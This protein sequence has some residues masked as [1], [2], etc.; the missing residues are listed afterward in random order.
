[1][2][3]FAPERPQTKLT[4]ILSLRRNLATRANKKLPQLQ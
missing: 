4:K 1:M 3:L 2:I